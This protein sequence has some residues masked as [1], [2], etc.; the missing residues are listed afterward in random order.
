MYNIC[1]II[2][3]NSIE[4][5]GGQGGNRFPSSG[6]GQG[7]GKKRA[8]PDTS[9]VPGAKKARKC[10]VCGEEGNDFLFDL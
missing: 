4:C 2:S 6:A 3:N 5:I 1:I 8:Q 10:G 7:R 9:S